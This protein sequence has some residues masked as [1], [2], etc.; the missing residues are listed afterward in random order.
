MRDKLSIKARKEGYKSRSAY[1]LLEINKKYKIIKKDDSVLDLGCWPGSWLQVVYKITPHVTGVDLRETKLNNIKTYKLD[2]FSDKIFYLGKF[3]VILSDVA[4]Q[5]SGN[6]EL[7]QYRGYEL[8]SRAFDIACKVLKK[9]GSFL[10]KVF[11]SGDAEL[12]L[13]KMKE[14]FTIAKTVKPSASKKKSK[15]IYYIGLG[16]K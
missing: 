11:Q 13:K 9:R 7:D 10:V 3:D 2:I 6:R 12:L 4:P 15:E 16:F 14:K 1:K 5:T 8:S